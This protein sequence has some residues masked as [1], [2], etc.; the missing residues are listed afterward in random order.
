MWPM[1]V[2]FKLLISQREDVPITGNSYSLNICA[3]ICAALNKSIPGPFPSIFRDFF[4]VVFCSVTVILRHN[5]N[6]NQA[7]LLVPATQ[8]PK[9]SID[10][11]VI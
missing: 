5:W 11:P 6:L 2:F 10:Q 3:L 7:L 8:Y 9:F 4:V 1:A